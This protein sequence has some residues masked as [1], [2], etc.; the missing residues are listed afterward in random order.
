MQQSTNPKDVINQVFSD[1]GLLESKTLDEL[2]I[3]Q[4][5]DLNNIQKGFKPTTAMIFI[6]QS[7]V[8]NSLSNE[9]N[10]IAK[11][12]KGKI[13]NGEKIDDLAYK[14][15]KGLDFKGS[16]EWKVPLYNI[17]ECN[18]EQ[19][20]AVGLA[21]NDELPVTVVSGPPGTGK[22]QLGMNLT[23]EANRE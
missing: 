21:M 23:A 12:W 11:I 1:L 17:G 9:L 14:F 13:D 22:T 7:G 16:K 20:M 8:Y 5:I 15:L 18:Y 19:S 4:N 2:L 6:S 10:Q 3:I